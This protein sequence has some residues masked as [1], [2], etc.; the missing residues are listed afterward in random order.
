[1]A[2]AILSGKDFRSIEDI[3]KHAEWFDSFKG[4][5][6]FTKENT[7]D[8]LKKEIGKT[9]VKV[10]EDAGVYKCTDEGREAFVRFIESI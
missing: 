10:L 4:N 7:E 8:I 1:M 5:Y 6:T 9:F 3:E 2:D